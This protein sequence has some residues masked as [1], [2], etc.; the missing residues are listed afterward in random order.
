MRLLLALVIAVCLPLKAWSSVALP[1]AGVAH[2]GAAAACHAGH[3][4][5]AHAEASTPAGGEHCQ[6]EQGTAPHAGDCHHLSMALVPAAA[7]LHA[8][9]DG[10]SDPPATAPTPLVSIVLDVLHPPPLARP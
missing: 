10:V 2:G 1:S 3:D 5:H 8:A 6:H 7:P 4:G 9:A